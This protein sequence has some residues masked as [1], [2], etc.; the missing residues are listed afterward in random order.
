MSSPAVALVFTSGLVLHGALVARWPHYRLV[1]EDG[2]VAVVRRRAVLAVINA[3]A[4]PA[5]AERN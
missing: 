5:P 4:P 2:S 3:P 1:L